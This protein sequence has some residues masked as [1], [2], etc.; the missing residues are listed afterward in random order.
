MTGA[1]AL[2]EALIDHRGP[3]L[4]VAPDVPAL[5]LKHLAAVRS[6]LA[7]GVLVSV[8]PTNDSHL[9]LVALLH[10]DPELL[11]AAC[12][13]FEALAP[14]VRDA[15]GA[16]GMVR[17]ERRLTTVGDARALLADPLASADVVAFLEP[18]RLTGEVDSDR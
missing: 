8:G 18:L 15:G 3:V 1:A 11:D 17:S 14:L 4:L 13:G 6:D 10:A 16:L 2:R 9:F 12:T 7:D 5:G